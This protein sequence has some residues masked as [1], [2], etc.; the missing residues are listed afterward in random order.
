[1]REV[2]EARTQDEADF[3]RKS[4]REKGLKD[5]SAILDFFQVLHKVFS[6]FRV[7]LQG[8]S[9]WKY[10]SKILLTQGKTGD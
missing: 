2:T 8:Q 5:V 9:A 4:L 10:V 3:R 7:C 1:M 6:C